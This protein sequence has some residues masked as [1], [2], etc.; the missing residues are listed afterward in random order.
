MEM[1]DFIELFKESFD[2]LQEDI[3][4]STRFKEIEQWTSMQALLLI[5]HVDDTTGFVF[6]SEHVKDAATIEDLFRI[7]Q[8]G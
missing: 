5:A 6:S 8:A 4:P 3:T 1:H 2:D 7:F